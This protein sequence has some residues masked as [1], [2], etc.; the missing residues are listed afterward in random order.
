MLGLTSQH[1]VIHVRFYRQS[2][3]LPIK[4]RR[5]KDAGVTLTSHETQRK[6]SFDEIPVD[7]S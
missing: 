1:A 7:D 5:T 2:Y 3:P 4:P 6:T